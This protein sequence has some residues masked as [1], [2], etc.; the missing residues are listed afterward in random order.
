MDGT[1]WQARDVI[2][3]TDGNVDPFEEQTIQGIESVVVGQC[4]LPVFR[5]KRNLDLLSL[6]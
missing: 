1:I 4:L 6:A 3:W 5:C 2:L